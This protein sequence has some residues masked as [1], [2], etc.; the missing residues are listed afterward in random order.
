MAFKHNRR[1]VPS[2][3]MKT[4]RQQKA[5]LLPPPTGE[6][7]PARQSLGDCGDAAR[8]PMDT[9]DVRPEKVAK[10]RKL[11]AHRAYPPP[12]VVQSLAKQIA[13]FF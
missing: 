1:I 2:P 7:R 12:E 8:P 6:G 13:L 5:A 4:R 11:V 3:G 9:S 10:A